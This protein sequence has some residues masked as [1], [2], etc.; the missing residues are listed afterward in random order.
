MPEV[1]L[2]SVFNR[3]NRAATAPAHERAARVIG[4]SRARVLAALE[5]P[6]TT[7]QVARLIGGVP[8]TASEH[9]TGLH[10]ADLVVR[11]RVGRHVYYELSDRG[12]CLLELLR[13]ES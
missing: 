7:A 3:S 6:Q 1:E 13:D 12:R 11:R 9:L 5:E 10:S 2:R 4:R 8:S